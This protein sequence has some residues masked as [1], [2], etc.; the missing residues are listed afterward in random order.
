MQAHTITYENFFGEEKT[1]T[2]YFNLTRAEMELLNAHYQSDGGLTGAIEQFTIEDADNPN[3]G[4]PNVKKIMEVF[5]E[6]LSRSYGER[7]GDRFVKNNDIRDE[8]LASAEYSKLFYELIQGDM[9]PWPFMKGI[10]PQGTNINVPDTEGKSASQIAR[11]ASEARLQGHQAKAE[12]E[13]TTVVE[14][15]APPVLLETEAEKKDRELDEL[16]KK[17]AGYEDNK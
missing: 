17:L 10:F 7:I 15:T 12:P 8:F 13:V 2:L 11:E 16:R 1:K 3:R 6:L 5:A 9:D 14:E 4:E